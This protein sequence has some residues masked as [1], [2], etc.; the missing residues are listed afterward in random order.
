MTIR[1]RSHSRFGLPPTMPE[2]FK[3]LADYNRRKSQG[4]VHTPEYVERMEAMQASFDQWAEY[5]YRGWVGRDG[6]R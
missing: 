5:A 6:D 1:R 2:H 3:E 4:I